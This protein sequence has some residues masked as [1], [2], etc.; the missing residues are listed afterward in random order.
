MAYSTAVAWA[1]WRCI[2]SFAA[3]ATTMRTRRDKIGAMATE[4]TANNGFFR[5]LQRL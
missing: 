1:F 4:N 2:V 3:C 5:A